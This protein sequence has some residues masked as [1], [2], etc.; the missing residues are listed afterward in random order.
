MKGRQEGLTVLL[1]ALFTLGFGCSRQDAQPSPPPP[2]QQEYEGTIVAVGDSLTAG[3]GVNAEEAYPALLGKKLQAAGLNFRVVN[4]GSSG[5]TS[6]GTLSRISWVLNLKPDIVIL[7]TGANDGLRGIDP[8][9]TRG[10]LLRLVDICKTGGVT[11]VL[12][13]MRMVQ[14]LGEAYT[15]AFANIYPEVAR[16]RGVILIPFFLEGVAGERRLNQED[17]IHP[18]AAG[19]RKVVES[20]YPYVV[21]AIEQHRKQ[22]RS[23][24]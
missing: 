21:R 14:N 6:S 4:A 2:Q 20:V 11:V 3:L 1:M 9:L 13:G 23:R 17:G 19:Y 8:E 22:V 16:E 15:T 18:T 10:N 5:E 24:G 12:A 7:E